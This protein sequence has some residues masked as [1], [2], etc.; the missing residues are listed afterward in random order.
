MK[1]RIT[2]KLPFY[3]IFTFQL[4]KSSTNII[5]MIKFK[6]K[7]KNKKNLDDYLFQIKSVIN[8]DFLSFGHLIKQIL[9]FKLT[10]IIS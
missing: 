4:H 5:F 2:I 6:V 1:T 10:V 7:I 3:L 9:N 8:A